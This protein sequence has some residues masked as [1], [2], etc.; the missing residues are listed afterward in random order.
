MPLGSVVGLASPPPSRSV[1]VNIFLACYN[2]EVMLP[3]T[4]AYYREQFPKAAIY[5]M[6]DWSTD[7]SVQVARALNVSVIKSPTSFSAK[8]TRVYPTPPGQYGHDFTWKQYAKVGSW[9]I[10]LDMDELL[11]ISQERL[12]EEDRRGTTV[13]RTHGIELVGNSNRSDLSDLR[14]ET[15]AKGRVNRLFNK[16]IA[17]KVGYADPGKP[18]GVESVRFAQGSHT[19]EMNGTIVKS[20]HQWP[21]LH[22]GDLGLAFSL[23]KFR[24][25]QKRLVVSNETRGVNRVYYH[26]FH[27][28]ERV[29]RRFHEL[30]QLALPV[31]PLAHCYR[32]GNH[33]R[34]P[35]PSLELGVRPTGLSKLVRSILGPA[36]PPQAW[37][38]APPSPTARP[39]VTTSSCAP[40]R[41]HPRPM[42][43]RAA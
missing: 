16:P 29:A 23:R 9:V 26:S 31:P 18:R 41:A 34:V 7:R 12:D 2:Q 24:M 21:L 30:E 28:D 10:T 39:P 43:P 40:P 8:A 5:I 27:S 6:D 4:W 33:L 19:A 35:D 20:N 1:D 14:L 36:S 3:K 42:A 38:P 13:L 25:Y 22:F 32:R 15:I 37:P 11:C 17:F